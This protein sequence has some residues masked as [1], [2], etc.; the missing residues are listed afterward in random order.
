[1]HLVWYC[2]VTNIL[3]FAELHIGSFIRYEN[4]LFEIYFFKCYI[5]K[6]K[7][8][9]LQL[10]LSIFYNYNDFGLFNSYGKIQ[11]SKTIH[12]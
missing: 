7:F 10:F 4:T 12:I 9:T 11:F 6:K 8:N 3:H 2:I 1:M 5:V